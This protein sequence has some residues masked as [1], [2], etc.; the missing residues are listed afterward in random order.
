MDE[1]DRVETGAI[2]FNDDWPGM[3]IRG[4]EAS[5]IAGIIHG[6]YMDENVPHLGDGWW[7]LKKFADDIMNNVMVK[8]D[9]STPA[10]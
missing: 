10:D 5:Y 7:Y 4:D 2:Q 9:N 8:H 1:D 6:L 3:F